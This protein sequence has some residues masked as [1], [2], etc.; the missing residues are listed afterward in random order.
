MR[1]NSAP[2]PVYVVG[3]MGYTGMAYYDHSLCQALSECGEPT[4]LITSR[5]KIV[6]PQIVSY[7]IKR[8]FVNTCGNL[9][10]VRKGLNY[11]RAMLKLCLSL[12]KNRIKLVHFQM[13]EVPEFDL[14]IFA[15]LKLLRRK[16]VFTPHNIYSFKKQNM[17][18]IAL[19]YRLSNIIIVH[20]GANKDM[21]IRDFKIDPNKIHIIKHGNYNYFLGQSSDRNT[22]KQ[23]INIPQDKQMILLF[24]SIRKG[25]SISTALAAIHELKNREDFVFV[26]AGKAAKEYDMPA[27]HQRIQDLGIADCVDIRNRF[28]ED[29]YIEHYYKAADIVLI[30][31]VES[32]ESGVLK[33]AFS[34]G[35]PVIISDL[36]VFRDDVKDNENCLLFERGNHVE[37]ATKIACLL[38][39]PRL[40]TKIGKNAKE[41]SDRHWNWLSSA[42]KTK[43]V[44]S[45]LIGTESCSDALGGEIEQKACGQVRRWSAWG[46]NSEA[47]RKPVSPPM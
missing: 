1:M 19:L 23:K 39:D 42:Q 28:I 47:Q 6:A 12:V 5:A 41:Y 27:L 9:S 45:T 20:N 44:Y 36:E 38:G 16:I 15:I 25:K 24:G 33:Y 11:A 18:V 7:D 31:Y 13:L 35:S 34:C 29:E 26:M 21:L 32:Y 17:S 43:Q 40:A 46:H 4:V 2:P 8:F 10:R 30:P 22:S 37:L 3:P 14:A